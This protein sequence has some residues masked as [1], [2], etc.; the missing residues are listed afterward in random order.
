ME[1]LLEH[2]GKD[3]FKK[4]GISVPRSSLVTR[5][6]GITD[7]PLP[8]FLKS[9]VKTSDRKKH[10]GIVRVGNEKEFEQAKKDIFSASIQGMLPEVLLA[11]EEVKF[12]GEY[13]ASITFSGDTQSPVVSFSKEGGTGIDSAAKV[14][15]PVLLGMTDFVIRDLLSIARVPYAAPI[16]DVLRKLWDLFR[17]E[18]LLLAEINP[19]FLIADGTLVAGDAKII[20]DIPKRAF[21]DL[22]GDVGILAS[23]GGASMLNM[24]ILGRAGGKPANYVE[25]SGNP[26]AS[27][28]EELTI[29]VL[30]KKGLRGAWVIGGTA[31]FTDIYETLRGFASGLEKV[32]PK[33][34]Y[35]IVIRRDGPRQKEAF[36]ML[37]TFAKEKG[38]DLHI[39]GPEKS[40]AESAKILVKLMKK[41]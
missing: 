19:L 15:V 32:E 34:K 26:P 29:K 7:V 3:L 12:A 6:D 40:M 41:A 4:Y 17:E 39:F 25:Y 28:V 30:S 31:N 18:K 10:G 21:L 36:E 8:F 38:F 14:P 1:L 35:P 5:E 37:T 11:E 2:E 24:D 20:R 16:A 27:L 13:Y 9:Q 22:G 33:P 23:G